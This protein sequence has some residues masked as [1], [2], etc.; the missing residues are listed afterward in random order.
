M[1]KAILVH[2]WDGSPES[3]WYQN[4]K[5]E[6]ENKGFEVII[7]E[8]PSP[9]NPKIEKWV[10]HLN[11]ICPKPN[12]ETYFIGHSIGCQTI[13]RYLEQ[14]STKTKV[15]KIILIA[16]WFHLDNLEDSESERIAK[17]WIE[18]SLNF[19][20]INNHISSMT[21]IFSD[22]DPWVPLSDR[23]IFRKFFSAKTIVEHNKGHFTESDGVTT[24]PEVI[25]ELITK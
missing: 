17:P 24:F 8:M 5:K 21:C 13:L 22:N 4:T 16:P 3:D 18:N 9:A 10:E 25:T 7:P 23:E 12:S 11:S 1:K 2:R 20:K 6:L 19:E 14:L 15:G